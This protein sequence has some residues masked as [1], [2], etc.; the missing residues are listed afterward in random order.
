LLAGAESHKS[1][2]EGCLLMVPCDPRVREKSES[3]SKV[4]SAMPDYINN[5]TY[6]R[7]VHYKQVGN[8]RAARYTGRACRLAAAFPEGDFGPATGSCLFCDGQLGS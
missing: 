6:T 5:Q 1:S 7:S 4:L 3:V 8:F 2:R